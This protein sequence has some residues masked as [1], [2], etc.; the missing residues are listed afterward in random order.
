VDALPY[1]S[2]LERGLNSPSLETL[3]ALVRVLDLDPASVL[4]EPPEE[5]RQSG[6]RLALEAQVAQAAR[7]LDDQTLATL[8]EI[9]ESLRK[10]SDKS[11][12]KGGKPSSQRKR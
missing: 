11:P 3:A 10:L 7:A 1:L 9:S 6:Q 5:R 8:L 4:G 12:G 2:K